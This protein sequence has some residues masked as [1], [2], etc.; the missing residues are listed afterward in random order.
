MFT[1]PFHFPLHRSIPYSS[2]VIRDA[3]K[4]AHVRIETPKEINKV[5]MVPTITIV[6]VTKQTLV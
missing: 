3:Q 6:I 4:Q 5:G 1:V 2:P